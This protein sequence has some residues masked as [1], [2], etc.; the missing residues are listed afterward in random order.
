M[1]VAV[2]SD[3]NAINVLVTAE[4]AVC[5]RQQCINTLYQPKHPLAF[6]FT[7]LRD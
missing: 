6:T 3:L 1:P 2:Y 7:E 4:T 5:S